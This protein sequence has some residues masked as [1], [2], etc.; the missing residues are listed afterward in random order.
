MTKLD[1]KNGN[2]TKSDNFPWDMFKSETVSF[3][4]R[5]I[6]KYFNDFQNGNFSALRL[7]LIQTMEMKENQTFS[8]E[9]YSN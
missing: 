2:E 7:R 9:A 3:F 6:L 8:H 5:K 4:D 1:Q